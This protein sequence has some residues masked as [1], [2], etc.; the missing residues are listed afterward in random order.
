M[1]HKVFRALK[2]AVLSML[3]LIFCDGISEAAPQSRMRITTASGV[4]VRMRPEVAAEEVMRLPIGS[5]VEELESFPHTEKIAGVEDR[6]YR[7]TLPDGKNKAGSLAVSLSSSMRRK[8][9][10]V[11]NRSQTAA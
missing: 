1:Q 2:V 6:W 4:R 7:V 8:L 10:R 11:I 3:L 5:V 9:P